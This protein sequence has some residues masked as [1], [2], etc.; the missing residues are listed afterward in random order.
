MASIEL[1]KSHNIKTITNTVL[2]KRNLNELLF[3]LSLADKYKHKALFQ[4]I[5][6]YDISETDDVIT[7]LRPNHCEMQLAIEYLINQK[8]HS[9]NVGNS[10][11]FLR[12]IQNTWNHQK[13]IR[14]HANSLFCT[15]DPMG[16]ILPCCFDIRQNKE[17]N[18]AELGFEQ[19]F[20]NSEKNDFTRQCKGCYC[21]AYIESNL[22]FSF[23]VS[24]CINAFSIV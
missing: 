9:K 13:I 7:Q 8:H 22:A 24:A 5:F 17:Y 14:C 21:N 16:Y 15:V 18:A 19:A 1:L 11:A 6:Y 4:P 23:H 20:Q 3:V 10:V 2:T 12:Y